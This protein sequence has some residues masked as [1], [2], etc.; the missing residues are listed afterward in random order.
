[1]Q[2]EDTSI[3]V[4]T[5][6]EAAESAIKDLT[7]AGFDMKNLSIV[8]KGFHTE[9]KVAGFYTVGD[10]MKF[11]GLNGAFWGGFWGLFLGGVVLTI[12]IVGH[13]VVLGYLATT[14]ISAVEGAA[15]VGG[16]SALGAAL[17]S[18]GIPKDSVLKYEAD[19]KADGFVVMAHGDAEEMALA[20]KILQQGNPSS[21]EVH[22]GHE[23]QLPLAVIQASAS[24]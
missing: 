19:V 1:M 5:T 10:R 13:V 4:F 24:A 11:W 8:G 9:E 12:P 16:F 20:K 3:A 2:T 7:K 17:Y 21:L 14:L 23:R 22:A 18:L 6:H 15:L